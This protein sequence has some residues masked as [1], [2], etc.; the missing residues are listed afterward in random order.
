MGTTPLPVPLPPMPSP[1]SAS[2]P[3][4]PSLSLPPNERSSP[5]PPT[6]PPS[7]APPSGSAAFAPN[8][9]EILDDDIGN[10][11]AAEDIGVNTVGVAGGCL[12]LAAAASVVYL[13]GRRRGRAAFR[14]SQRKPPS[15]GTSNATLTLQGKSIEHKSEEDKRNPAFVQSTPSMHSAINHISPIPQ[16][17]PDR[18]PKTPESQP[19]PRPV[20]DQWV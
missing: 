12:L 15:G 16:L 20:L 19:L 11:S 13:V 4:P 7:L 14:S 18:G 10:V 2:F 17:P 8:D 3:P 9:Q 6:L 1:L 5:P